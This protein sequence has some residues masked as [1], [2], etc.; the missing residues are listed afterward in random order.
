MTLTLNFFKPANTFQTEK[1]A[2][3]ITFKNM[4]YTCNMQHFHSY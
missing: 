2:S 1:E 4:P 3:P